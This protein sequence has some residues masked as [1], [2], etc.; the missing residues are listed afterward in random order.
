MVE[1]GNQY[2][3]LGKVKNL[4]IV[5]ADA[6]TFVNELK[7]S[8]QFDLVMVDCFE[9]NEIPKK[10][11]SVS[12]LKNLKDHSRFVLVNRL[13]WYKYK[14]KTSAFFRSI[15]PAFFFVKAHT[16]SNVII[17]LV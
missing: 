1:L 8:D 5:I 14:I 17:S 7:S 15:S 4:N 13:W 10:L 6:L 9:G 16:Y 2:F 3:H 11:E 12:F